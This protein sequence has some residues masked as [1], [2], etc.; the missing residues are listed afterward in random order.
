[1]LFVYRS[2]FGYRLTASATEPGWS[3]KPR[4]D[5]ADQQIAVHK[6]DNLVDR[7]FAESR[8]EAFGHLGQ[9]SSIE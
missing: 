1:V 2:R 8:I 3:A 5:K 6:R 9:I 7:I 4:S